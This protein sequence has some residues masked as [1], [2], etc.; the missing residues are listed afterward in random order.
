MSRA[1]LRRRIVFGFVLSGLTV[2]TVLLQTAVF[3]VPVRMSGVVQAGAVDIVGGRPGRRRTTEVPA[4]NIDATSTGRQTFV[5]FLV[6]HTWKYFIHS[7]LIPH[8][9]SVFTEVYL[10]EV[11]WPTHTIGMV[12]LDRPRA[13][14]LSAAEDAK[15]LKTLE[16]AAQKKKELFT[17]NNHSI[18]ATCESY[19]SRSSA[20]VA[21]SF[22]FR[23]GRRREGGRGGREDGGK[24]GGGGG[25]E[26][27]RAG[28]REGG[29]DWGTKGPRVV[30]M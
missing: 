24:G 28:W 8:Y 1:C 17:C 15:K 19:V 23:Q 9:T 21:F 18:H 5:E 20:T 3:L 27:G 29:G 12:V 10:P 22:Q 2:L 16:A 4:R 26:G 14:A 30:S 6:Y 7:C 13:D 11:A 25:R